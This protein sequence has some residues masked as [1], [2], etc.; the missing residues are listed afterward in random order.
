M[1]KRGNYFNLTIGGPSTG[2]TTNVTTGT[3]T[4]DLTNETTT[5][6]LTTGTTTTDMTTGTAAA[7]LQP[8]R[9]S[10]I[11][12]ADGRLFVVAAD[13]VPG[14][15]IA[16]VELVKKGQ[17]PLIVVLAVVGLRGAGES[18]L[19]PVGICDWLFVA[20]L[21]NELLV[22]QPVA[23]SPDPGSTVLAHDAH[24]VTVL[25]RGLNVHGGPALAQPRAI[26]VSL[27]PSVALPAVHAPGV[28]VVIAAE[29]V[30]DRGTVPVTSAD[31]ERNRFV[32]SN[33]GREAPANTTTS[34][35]T[36][37]TTINKNKDRK[38]VV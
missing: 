12:L 37:N 4:T 18:S 3:T 16:W 17:A 11:V 24:N 15:E 20:P 27:L 34:N 9:S 5:T 1:I 10:S 31:V 33:G 38:S 13:V 14:N 2:A 22:V 29:G 7:H 23:S 21:P 25:G 8:T 19:A 35:T 30:V 36:T 32:V 26:V 6:D 28:V